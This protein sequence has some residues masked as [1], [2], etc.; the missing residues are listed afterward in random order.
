MVG[1]RVGGVVQDGGLGEVPPQ[2]AEIFDVVSE[3]AGAVVLIEP[4]SAGGATDT[5]THVNSLTSWFCM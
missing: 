4:V 3:D 5:H 1:V 2:N